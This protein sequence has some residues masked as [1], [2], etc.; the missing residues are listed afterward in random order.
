M[1]LPELPPRHVRQTSASAPT[2][3][4][5][6]QRRVGRCAMALR[7]ASQSCRLASF[8]LELRIVTV[9]WQVG[10]LIGVG[11]LGFHHLLGETFV[12]FG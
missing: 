1:T 4:G 2:D 6:A 11:C 9:W 8:L 3:P 10:H 7:H 5:G 12:F